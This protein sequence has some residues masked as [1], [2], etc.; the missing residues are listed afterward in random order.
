MSSN[1]QPVAPFPASLP[2]YS[3]SS[4]TPSYSTYPSANEQRLASNG[5][6]FLYRRLA[7]NAIF[8]KCH[9]RTGVSLTL[10]HQEDG[11]SIPWYGRDAWIEGHVSLA[12]SV[13]VETVDVK[14]EGRLDLI[15]AEGGKKSTSMLSNLSSLWR[16]SKLSDQACPHTLPFRIRMPSTFIEHDGLRPLP[17]TYDFICPGV[18][19]LSVHSSY[20]IRIIITRARKFLW[21]STQQYVL[22]TDFIYY[23]RTRTTTPVMR[24]HLSF[25]SALKIAP[26]EYF[27]VECRVNTRTESA[28]APINC[29]LFI[30]S[31]QAYAI[32]E[33]IPF[34]LHLAAPKPSLDAL[35]P[36][37]R[38]SSNNFSRAISTTNGRHRTIR[39]YLLRQIR[40]EVRGQ[41]VWRTAVLGEG[42]LVGSPPQY[43]SDTTRSGHE[44]CEAMD[45]DGTVQV[46]EKIDVGGFAVDNLV[47]KDFIVLEITPP[48]PSTNPLLVTRHTHPIR[49]V[50]DTCED[51]WDV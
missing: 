15:I 11:A 27:Q 22:K 14:L 21:N 43:D 8:E 38:G 13:H 37:D 19:G 35:F 5:A 2:P 31:S 49:L 17:P 48:N 6:D 26:E 42:Q 18:P 25:S 23:P 46:T 30:P 36:I 24:T 41:R 3:P 10:F 44:T 51:I 20:T 4:N 32:T 33:S 50:T 7:P 28:L 29:N 40:V 45:W 12:D 34:H 47:V 9:K 1:D 39:V 16:S